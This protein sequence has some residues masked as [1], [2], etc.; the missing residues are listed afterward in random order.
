MSKYSPYEQ[1]DLLLLHKHYA[2]FLKSR[3]GSGT[4]IPFSVASKNHIIFILSCGSWL[5]SFISIALLLVPHEIKFTSITSVWNR[6]I[7]AR[8]FYCLL[9]LQSYCHSKK[10]FIQRPSSSYICPQKS[11]CCRKWKSQGRRVFASLIVWDV[12]HE[13]ELSNFTFLFW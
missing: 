7:S 6:W 8:H 2:V 1:N 12:Q 5:S 3:V 4:T 13:L 11:C 10:G 9:V